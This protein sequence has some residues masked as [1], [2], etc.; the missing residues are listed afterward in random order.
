MTTQVKGK[1]KIRT[2]FSFCLF[3]SMVVSYVLVQS[4]PE[5]MRMG[6]EYTKIGD[7]GFLQQT[8]GCRVL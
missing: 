1:Q 3:E 5:R 6:W 7:R 4:F 8:F 2:N